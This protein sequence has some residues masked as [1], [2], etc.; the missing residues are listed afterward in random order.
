MV[1]AP[2][3]ESEAE[4]H[5]EGA[6][7]GGFEI[8]SVH[9]FSDVSAL[10]APLSAPSTR[11]RVISQL[12]GGRAR[13]CHRFCDATE[14]LHHALGD[15]L[16]HHAYYSRARVLAPRKEARVLTRVRSVC[17]LLF[18]GFR[19]LRRVA[20]ARELDEPLLKLFS[21]TPIFSCCLPI[22]MCCVLVSLCCVLVRA[23]LSVF[24]RRLAHSAR[25]RHR[26]YPDGGKRWR[27]HCAGL[28]VQL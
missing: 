18:C 2:W 12:R 26:R 16:L 5:V 6:H 7:G 14:L 28:C 24:V 9:E 8:L 1:E 23:Y 22:Q 3:A 20:A 15:S 4:G 11:S 27:R 25:L 17:C 19:P 10:A 13:H 21:P